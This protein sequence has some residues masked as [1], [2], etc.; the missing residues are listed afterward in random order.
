M[1]CIELLEEIGL[2]MVLLTWLILHSKLKLSVLSQLAISLGS[3]ESLSLESEVR[4][5]DRF[6]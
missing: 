3:F 4:D 2:E 1:L 5:L 6:C